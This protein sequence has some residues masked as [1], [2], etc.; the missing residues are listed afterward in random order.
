MQDAMIRFLNMMNEIS[1][2]INNAVLDGMIRLQEPM[3][4]LLVVLAII[5]IA[6]NW[7]MYFASESWN[8]GNLF[9]KIIHIGFYAFLIRNWKML[10]LTVK[11]TGEQLGIAAGG[12]KGLLTPNDILTLGV[13]KVF[14]AIGKLLEDLPFNMEAFTRIL[15]AVILL[16]ALYAFL[17]IACT[18]FFTYAE[19]MIVG[20]LSIVLL[21]WSMTKWTKGI[22]DKA[23][24]ILLTG[25]V[26][27]MVCAF[28]VSL[29]SGFLEVSFENIDPHKPEIPNLLLNTISIGF[30][31]F[32]V[33]K[34]VEYAGAM[35]N[36]LTVS[37]PDMMGATVGRATSYATGRVGGAVG[38]A[39][40]SAIGSGARRTKGAIVNA[41][42]KGGEWCLKYGAGVPL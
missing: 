28:M 9:V 34:S 25:A 39:V 40:G 42:K 1:D 21:P 27:I 35:T 37:T 29:I 2:V 12:D 33:G 38:N 19:F 31:A 23:W 22:A 11:K 4:E 8:W 10:L 7:E 16:I 24:G 36:G 26:K 5:G 14:T 20:G 32:L 15:G 30:L 6:S 13:G 41:A 17:K 18:L 3:V